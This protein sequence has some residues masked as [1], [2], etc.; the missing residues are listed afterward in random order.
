MR[1]LYSAG[2]FLGITG[3]AVVAIAQQPATSPV[4]PTA[5][6]PPASSSPAQPLANIDASHGGAANREAPLAKFEPLA[7]FPESTQ[8]AV[9]SVL[10]AAEW[11]TRMNQPQGR[12]LFGYNPA[13]RRPMIGDHDLKQAR[14]ALALA[15]AARFSGDEKQA[16][17]ASQAIL[18]SLAATRIDPADATCR[19]PVHSSLVCN[20]VGFASVVIQ[21]ILEL[22]GADSKL[23]T[24]A[25]ELC[26]FLHKQCKADGSVDYTDATDDDPTKTDPAGL[27]EFPGLALSA[28]MS[29]N[30]VRPAPWK[31]ETVKKGIVYYR[32]VFRAKP[33]AMLAATLTPACAELY[34]QTKVADGAAAT[35][36]FNDWLCTAQ[37]RGSDPRNPQWAGGFRTVLDNLAPDVPP[38]PETGLYLQ[39]LAYACQLTRLTPDLERFTKYKTSALGAVMFLTG[40][41][42]LEMNTRHFENTFRVN[43]L[44]GGFHLSPTDGNLRID[45]TADAVTG[46]IR[47]LGSGAEK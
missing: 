32:A 13:L 30:R 7:A 19:V 42:Y 43:M 3:I 34:L 45:A 20:R 35:F 9:R 26:V 33:N 47:F 23:F 8:N 37:I 25:E 40:L 29:S 2:L 28:I 38:G 41:Q 22:P 6:L 14:G 46:L 4:S 12:F 44:I 18:T 39:S 31:V 24:E 1:R 15:Q 27:N 5:K 11:M 10:L 36:E 16:A 17:M 21:A